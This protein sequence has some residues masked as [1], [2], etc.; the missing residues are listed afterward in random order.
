MPTSTLLHQ[1]CSK[2]HALEHSVVGMTYCNANSP[3]HQSKTPPNTAFIQ[4]MKPQPPTS[5]FNMI[6]SGGGGGG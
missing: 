5:G 2:T 3:H 1:H 4:A 6:I